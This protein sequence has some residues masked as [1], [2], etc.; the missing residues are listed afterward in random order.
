MA[1]QT[2]RAYVGATPMW[3]SVLGGVFGGITLVGLMAFTFIAGGNPA[4]VCN[5]FTLLAPIFALGVA[6]SAGFIGGAAA[7]SG[8]LG[9]AAQT[10]LLKFSAGG[11]LAILVIA[12]FA[13][14]QFKPQGCITGQSF[15]QSSLHY[16]LP[17]A[18]TPGSSDLEF[19]FAVQGGGFG[20]GEH[21]VYQHDSAQFGKRMLFRS[22]AELIQI[23]VNNR[24]LFKRCSEDDRA[25][26]L[27]SQKPEYSTIYRIWI[28]KGFRLHNAG[29]SEYRI[30]FE[31]N[32]LVSKAQ[33]H[34]R[35]TIRN[36]TN[37]Q[38]KHLHIDVSHSPDEC[39][40]DIATN[41]EFYSILG[42][43]AQQDEPQ[44]GGREFSFGLISSARAAANDPEFDLVFQI[45]GGTDKAL[46]SKAQSILVSKLNDPA[47]KERYLE[48][49]GQLLDGAQPSNA[50]SII[51]ILQALRSAPTTYRLPNDM[52]RKVLA[53]THAPIQ[54]LRQAARNY[55][56]SAAVVDTALVDLA[57]NYVASKEGLKSTDLEQ[58]ML[59]ATAARDIYYNTG[60]KYDVEYRGNYGRS[61]RRRE[62]ILD[63]KRSLQVG[64]EQIAQIPRDRNVSFAKSLYGLAY[65]LFSEIVMQD[66]E[67]KLGPNA[68]SQELD[69]YITSRWEARNT[70]LPFTPAQR[71]AFM[72]TI[73]RFLNHVSGREG[74]YFWPDHIAQLKN[75]KEKPVYECFSAATARPS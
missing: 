42:A 62:A 38:K 8:Q 9:G 54:N 22:D 30:D 40:S 50:Q 63:A 55:L 1:P 45:L 32:P 15:I 36:L 25:A 28:D 17:V 46:T 56:L 16:R 39:L 75:C 73:D 29:G 74:E 21:A 41:V 43:V 2:G 52:L 70:P 10:H 60:I 34:D 71:S 12:F 59:L 6:L 11:G 61:P 49:I 69:K 65:V 53:L 64:V 31:Y 58:Y 37:I 57:K 33:P 23:K 20:G 24:P 66:A 19:Q 67:K 18:V 68:A 44:A 48:K 35:L 47:V 13:F 7:A 27:F 51:N 3:A 26:A 72:A 14:Q 5:T 4:F